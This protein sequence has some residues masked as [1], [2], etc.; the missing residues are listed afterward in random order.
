MIRVQRPSGLSAVTAI[1]VMIGGVLRVV[2]SVRVMKDGQLLT[3]FTSAPPM[4]GQISPP[5]TSAAGRNSVINSA[6]V[7]TV[8]NGGQGPFSYVW[9]VFDDGGLPVSALSPVSPTTS[10]RISGVEAGGVYG[11]VF[12][13]TITDSLGQQAFADIIVQFSRTGV[14]QP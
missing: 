9:S 4:T 7:T 1:R 5:N 11:P 10:F 2:R 12:R 13:V 3:A 8:V 14:F 6:S